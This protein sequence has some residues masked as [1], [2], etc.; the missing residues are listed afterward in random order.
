MVQKKLSVGTIKQ[1]AF[2]TATPEE[3]FEVL[4]DPKKHTKMTGARATGAPKVGA[5]ITAWD[6]YITGKNLK[7]TKGK[8]IVQEWETDQWPEGY[9]ASTLKITIKKKGKG[10]ELTMVQTNVPKE[11][12]ADYADGWKEYYWAKMKK[13]FKK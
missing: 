3:V 6:G 7:L 4:M 8:L 9:K 10:T 1:K 12:V 2:F 5:R 11:Q 13:F